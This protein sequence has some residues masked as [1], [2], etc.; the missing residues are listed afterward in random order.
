MMTKLNGIE[1]I[2]EYSAHSRRTSRKSMIGST[3]NIYGKN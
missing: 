1:N 3:D 2:N